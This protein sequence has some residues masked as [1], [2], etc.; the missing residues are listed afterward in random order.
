MHTRATLLAEIGDRIARHARPDM[1]TSIDGVL[2]SKVATNGSTPDYTLTEPLLVVMAQGGKRLMLGD[3]A[4]EYR[5]GQCL[6]V[7]ATV[8]V[9]GHYVDTSAASPS[10]GFGLALRPAEIAAL[11]LRAPGERRRRTD[12]PES[13]ITTGDADV[14]LLDAVARMLR[15]LDRPDDAAVLASLIEREI[16]WRVLTGPLGPTLR[17]IGSADG[18]LAHVSRTIS[19]LR[20]NYAQPLRIDDLASMAGMSS[21]A[22]HRH[23]RGVTAMTP[24]QFQ[25]CIRLQ[26]ARSLLLARPGDVAGIGHAVGYDS[27]SQFNR[28]YRRLFGVPPG[29]DAERLRDQPTR[30]VAVV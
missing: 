27:P 25:K 7:A 20:D 4:Y 30:A 28:E 29:R 16:L 2:L 22:Y 21:S 17:Q 3:R 24:L 26:H 13:A 12:D 14:D 10:L 9:T 19:W 8:P 5:A 1:T 11:M 6:L 23:F 15:L 18:N